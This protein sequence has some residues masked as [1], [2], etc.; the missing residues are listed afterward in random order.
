M[1]RIDAAFRPPFAP[2]AANGSTPRAHGDDLPSTVARP[3]QTPLAVVGLSCLFPQADRVDQFW[4]NVVRGADGIVEIPPT[5]WNPADY[6]D[7]DPK[8]P[9]RT[10]ARR[11]GFLN[12]VDFDPMEFG[13]SPN[14]L[15][16]IDTSQL[17]GLLAA[18]RA[19]D[20]AGY[21][22]GRTFD[23]TRV[24]CILGVTGTLEMVIPLGARLG[25]PLW[26]RALKDAGVP[27]DVANDVVQRISEGYV[28]WQE[29]SFPGLLGNVVAGRIANRLNLL[30]TNCV[31]DA[32]CA[33]SLAA[34]HLAALELQSGRSDMVLTGGV[35][36]FN[37]IFMYLC[38]SKTP[39]LSPSGDAKP[40]SA[41]SDGTI[42]GE[43]VGMLVLKR[44]ADA[45]RDGDRIFAVIRGIG[46]SSDGAGNAVYAPKAEG[47]VRCLKDAYAVAGVDPGSVELLEA[48]GTG[49]KVG[50]ATEIQGLVDVFTPARPQESRWCAVGSVKS[51]IGHTKAA[52]GVA[53]LMKAILA[54]HHRVLPPT[55]KVDEPAEIVAGD[56][57]PFYVN[58]QSRPWMARNGQPRRAGVSAF[59]FGG[60]NFHCVVEEAPESSTAP[61]DPA[62]DGRTQIVAF[63]GPSSR[64][65]AAQLQA[66]PAELAWP[67]LEQRAAESRR[68]FAAQ[69]AC[70][71]TLVVERAGASAT[72]SWTDLR[73]AAL[74]GL[75]RFAD[76]DAWQ[77]PEGIFFG[78]GEPAGG[79]GFLFPGQGSQS[80]GMLRDLAVRFPSF[81]QALADADL[82]CSDALG[83]RL[84]D[85]IY[86]PFAF[87]DADRQ[88]QQQRL[89]ETQ[90]AQ[91]ALGAV[92]LGALSV[93]KSL[94]VSADAA[95]GHSYGELTA[96]CA[97]ERMQPESL[98]RLSMHRGRLMA[99]NQ[100][101]ASGMLA[102]AAP[103]AVVE[104]A[105]RDAVLDLVV[106]NRNSPTQV[107][108]SGRIS[109]LD[110]AESVLSQRN[111]RG[112]RLAVS[113]AFHSP[114]VAEAGRRFRPIL[115]GIDFTGGSLPVYAN[116]TAS[117]YPLEPDATRDLLARQIAHPVDFVREI[118]TMFSDGIRTFLEVGPGVVLT[119]LASSIL[120]GRGCRT[121]AL[122]S[123]NGRRSGVHDLALV[124]ADLA[125][126]GRSVA[127]DCWN[128]EPGLFSLPPNQRPNALT[129]PLSGANYRKPQTPRPP[130]QPDRSMM[131]ASV[132]ETPLHRT[133]EI[134]IAVAP[135]AAS[136]EIGRTVPSP[137]AASSPMPPV[138]DVHPAPTPPQFDRELASR[139]LRVVSEKTGYPPEMLAPEMSL[140]GDLGIDSIKRVEILSA[141]QEAMPHLPPVPPDELGR[142]VTLAD[143]IRLV[144]PTTPPPIQVAPLS[145]TSSERP[146]A[147]PPAELAT[148][149]TPVVFPSAAPIAALPPSTG[150]A[151][152]AIAL[153]Q[154]IHAE[155]ARIHR[156]FLET[157]TAALR[158]IEAL[159]R[160]QASPVVASLEPTSVVSAAPIEAP[161]VQR[162]VPRPIPAADLLAELSNLHDFT[163]PDADA[164]TSP[165]DEFAPPAGPGQSRFTWGDDPVRLTSE[166]DS[167]NRAAD[168]LPMAAAPVNVAT[169][170]F[171]PVIAAAASPT[172][173]GAAIDP[174]DLLAVVAEKT[175]YPAEMLQ[176]S[177]SLDQ[178]LGV[179]SI[180]RVEILSAVQE[181]IPGLPAVSP[182]DLGRLHTLGDIVDLLN[183]SAP[184]AVVDASAVPAVPVAVHPLGAESTSVA[185][186][187]DA[188]APSAAIDPA[189]VLAVVAEK[190][191]YPVEMLQLSMS[192]DQDL[193]IDSI[194]RVEILSAVQERLP[195]LPAVSPDD[196]GRLQTLSDVIAI[197]GHA[198]SAAAAPRSIEPP[199]VPAAVSNAFAPMER[200]PS[201]IA[202]SEVPETTGV[203]PAVVMAIVSEKT[204]YPAEMLRWEMQLDQDL[205]IDS[206]KRVE[207]LSAVQERVPGLPAVSPDDLGRL[208]TLNDVLDVL[209][210]ATSHAAP[211]APAAASFTLPSP[212][213]PASSESVRNPVNRI[214]S[215]IEPAI[216]STPTQPSLPPVPRPVESAAPM[217]ER[218]PLVRSVMRPHASP[219]KAAPSLAWSR[220][221]EIWIAEDGSD[222]P[223]ALA[224][225]LAGRDLRARVV[226]PAEIRLPGLPQ[227]LFGLILPAPVG[228]TNDRDLWRLLQLVQHCAP[229]LKKSAARGAALLATLVRLDG[230]HG[231]SSGDALKDP[232]SG[233][234]SGLCKTVR[235][236]WPGVVCKSIDLGGSPRNDRQMSQLIDELLHEGDVE[237]GFPNGERTTLSQVDEALSGVA[238]GSVARLAPH[239]VVLVSGG[240]RGVTAAAV[241][242]L[243][244]V[245]PLTFAVW[246]RSAPPAPEPDW[247]AGLKTAADLKRAL[248]ERSPRGTKPKAIEEQCQSILAAREATEV[249]ASLRQLGSRVVYRS[250]DV[251]DAEAV[252][253]AIAKLRSEFGPIRG[254]VHGAGVLADQRI[255]AK[256]AEQFDAVY[257]SKVI[258]LRNMLAN[259]PPN[260]LRLL[261]IFS[262]FT[263]R[264][265]RTGQV[266]YAIANEVLN[267][268]AQQF[269]RDHAN[270]HVASFNWGPWDG[271]MVRG[272]LR[273]LFAQEGIGLIPLNAGARLFA[274]EFRQTRSRPVE[275][276]VLGD[277]HRPADSKHEVSP[278]P[279]P[280]KSSQSVPPQTASP[281]EERLAPPLGTP[282][283]LT[284]ETVWERQLS[285]DSLPC[286]ASHVLGG[287]AVLPVALAMEWMAEAALLRQAGLA[288][289]GVSKVRVFKGIRLDSRQPLPLRC[290]VGKLTRS[291]GGY[292]LPV[293]L[294]SDDGR[295]PTIHIS[296]EVLLSESP[297]GV[298]GYAEAP[299]L[300]SSNLSIA[301][302]YRQKL[303]HGPDFHALQTIQNL[304]QT[305]I[306]AV[307]RVSP[308]PAAW[309]RNP[310]R[311]QWVFDPL[312]ID[313]AFQALIVWSWEFAQVPS[314]PCAVGGYR[315]Y[316]SPFPGSSVQLI[317]TVVG[318]Q[319]A[320]LRADVDFVGES[321]TLLARLTGVEMVL[322]AGLARAFQ[323]RTLEGL[324]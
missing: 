255:E 137:V 29:N 201:P 67:Q 206:I 173:R 268:L 238:I 277:L 20:H 101:D 21:G 200:E 214:P 174:A 304:G 68:N 94:S 195:G 40:F 220:G 205:G 251:R 155:T 105:I 289:H 243:A 321:R 199:A 150:Q 60:S 131:I 97:G 264:F 259:V 252:H 187:S 287:K 316:S 320:L 178:D 231:F 189:I 204:G 153:L 301:E 324:P 170:S 72:T 16:A 219:R 42:L 91:P 152:D 84:S 86:P 156:E 96:L 117:R 134:P 53:G 218:S 175:G 66:W 267:K 121:I 294:M 25:H 313:A 253:G 19:L 15:E 102:V 222:L 89:R 299:R 133:E 285:V 71:L 311:S 165:D 198:S 211:S 10:Y 317:A 3:T 119:G 237:V 308:P 190:T 61:R 322:D 33:S 227:E 49:T 41:Q 256:T 81:Q 314:L 197:L 278:P 202:R 106:A 13:I 182:D 5:H 176:L 323:H 166:N 47:Q 217:L 300:E 226:S 148:P 103:A 17:L 270:C 31:V 254:L 288:C 112:R 113:A 46:T 8:S 34:I 160:G 36:T 296:G 235:H 50:D 292:L 132:P 246:G 92:C 24:S 2:S 144:G 95:A 135:D 22:A 141:V 257:G 228:G 30:G 183:S 163:P 147:A 118:E 27:D 177:M 142:L 18:K 54:L 107:V 240:A 12:P 136:V 143:V 271:G 4:S 193:G 221:A 275:V 98:Y 52:A 303:F 87:R 179:D 145:A 73:A 78:R 125:A 203:D 39:A 233:G 225:R 116:V 274:D 28:P 290:A 234:L 230:C 74:A 32:A 213:L 298:A 161:R 180:K 181:R 297:L 149:S 247:L 162:A 23:R 212:G 1:S 45:E 126:E 191:G 140:D 63:S 127:L 260:D 279:A 99:E 242:A 14:N 157:Q 129:I 319:G 164:W 65:I 151:G 266:D 108:L 318:H 69:A 130:R 104:D 265:G 58:A 109:E 236:E 9:D 55:I 302:V 11:G 158:A 79:M 196:L 315:Q 38:F 139:V 146:V 293:Q 192:L 26:R 154:Q 59:G 223:Y 82:V 244:R 122:D 43:G 306:A 229:A 188:L 169:P 283:E 258:G 208:H 124:L 295:R 241:Q 312:V 305:G 93:L 310:L 168:P 85:V 37:D 64:H 276:L 307:A 272:G 186:K 263:G 62:W 120:S 172:L 261:A 224:D 100:S 262:S 7:S 90:I 115:D 159:S 57:S 110:R 51:Q 75:E 6:F 291:A 171:P 76:R 70:R 232:L 56:A 209:K 215:P 286:L 210:S 35:D 248:I 216:H 88:R 44:L 167:L 77:S 111:I 309:Q 249:L 282:P 280:V 284:F 185:V 273:D 269:A 194:K 239:D 128:P 80:V 245:Q 250:V 184:V 123:S 114:L 138:A 83:G 281:P 48:H 207:I